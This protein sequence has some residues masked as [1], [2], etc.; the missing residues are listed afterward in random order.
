[1]HQISLL[2]LRLQ[3]SELPLDKM[4][5]LLA[6]VTAIFET[7][8]YPRGQ[9]LGADD[10]LPLLVYIV[11][12]CGFI[13]AEIEAEFMYCLLQQ[14]LL[15]GEAGYYIT[16]LCSAVHVLKSFKASEN[17]GT[18][19]LDVS[20]SVFGILFAKKANIDVRLDSVLF[21]ASLLV[22]ITCHNTR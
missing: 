13:G 1:M 17:E 8:T 19:S 22:R 9:A 20:V 14:S 6:V 4:E 12:K 18:G 21:A 3:E 11:A 16:A 7:S 10:F 15:N 2:L 5:Y